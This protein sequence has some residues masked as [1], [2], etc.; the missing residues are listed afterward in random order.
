MAAA[1]ECFIYV[2]MAVCVIRL[3]RKLPDNPRDFKIPL[4]YVIPI[5]TIVVFSALLLGIFVDVSKD[6]AGNILFH[7]YWV[8]VVMA[9]FFVLC[10]LYTLLVVP[11]FKKKAAER[12][13]TRVRRR[14]GK[15]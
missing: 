7:N 14:P 1:L 11:I 4:G 15:E 5:I 3:R 6:Y 12:A 2:V 9:G 10:T 13:A 8:A